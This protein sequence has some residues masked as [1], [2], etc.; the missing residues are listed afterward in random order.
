MSSRAGDFDSQANEIINNAN[1]F[2]KE[3]L[4]ELDGRSRAATD[5]SKLSLYSI[6]QKGKFDHLLLI[7]IWLNLSMLQLQNKEKGQKD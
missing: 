1:V 6:S 5:H 4:A 2:S 3:R 7:I